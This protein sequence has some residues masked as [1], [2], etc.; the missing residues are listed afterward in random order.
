MVPDLVDPGVQFGR[1]ELVEVKS[2]RGRI[3]PRRPPGYG[4]NVRGLKFSALVMLALLP[5]ARITA[6]EGVD[7]RTSVAGRRKTNATRQP[8]RSVRTT[9]R[10]AGG[11]SWRRKHNVALER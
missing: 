2:C 4:R 11:S 6:P 10:T 9:V 1:N 7:Q 3:R 8:E 5:V